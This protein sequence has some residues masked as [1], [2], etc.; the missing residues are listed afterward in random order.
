MAH[1]ATRA[2]EMH[3]FQINT[4]IQF[5]QIL[6]SSTCFEPHGF[7]FRTTVCTHSFC[8]VGLY[9]LVSAV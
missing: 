2:N 7:I 8:T 4:S 3:T 1:Y 6:T 9:A 5:F